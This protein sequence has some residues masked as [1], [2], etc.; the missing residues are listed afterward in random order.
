MFL[1]EVGN[2]RLAEAISSEQSV[3]FWTTA[4]QS[5]NGLNRRWVYF[6]LPF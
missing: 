6:N 4:K 3:K 1:T 5:A 2:D